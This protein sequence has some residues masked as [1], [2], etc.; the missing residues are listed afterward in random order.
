MRIGVV[1]ALLDAGADATIQIANLSGKTM[2]S[3]LE[4]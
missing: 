1:E 2:A 3:D 4:N